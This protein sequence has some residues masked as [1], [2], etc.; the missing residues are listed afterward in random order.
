VYLRRFLSPRGLPAVTAATVQVGLAAAVMLL[1]APF[2]AAQPVRL[3]PGVVASVLTLGA[4]GTGLAYVWLTNIVAG[5]GATN[6]STVTYLT[7]LV[8]VV[9]GVVVLGESVTWNQ[10]LGAVVVVFGIA[11]SQGLLP[12]RRPRRVAAP[13]AREDVDQ[14][15]VL[16]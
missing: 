6:A 2:V 15:R 13:R 3:A 11:V 16:R 4:L 8:G 14:L 5:W 12:V 7:P 1:A 9:L 10:P